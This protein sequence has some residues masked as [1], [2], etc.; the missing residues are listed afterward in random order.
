MPSSQRNATP[1]KK[2]TG[3]SVS[4]NPKAYGSKEQEWL[5]QSDED[6]PWRGFTVVAT[7]RQKWQSHVYLA[8]NRSQTWSAQAEVGSQEESSTE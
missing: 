7:D 2:T 6:E 5:R 8:Q 1:E 4:Q 3:P